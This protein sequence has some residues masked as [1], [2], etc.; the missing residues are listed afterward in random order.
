MRAAEEHSRGM[1]ER[2]WY[3]EDM[4]AQMRAFKP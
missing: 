4:R 3:Y 1:R 2:G